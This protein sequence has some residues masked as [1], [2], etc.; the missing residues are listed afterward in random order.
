M[1]VLKIIMPIVV[2]AAIILAAIVFVIKRMLLGDTK[3]AVA[4]LS[5]VE[6]DVRKR[7]E[8]IRREIEEHEKEFAKRKAEAEADMQKRSEDAMKEIAHNREQVLESAKKESDRI[9][10][11]AAKSEERLRAQIALEMEEKAVGYSVQILQLVFSEKVT[12]EMDRL[13]IGELLDALEQVDSSSITVDAGL[14][15]FVTSHPMDAAQKAR[16]EQMLKDKFGVTV[17]VEEKI[18]KELLAGMIIKLGSLEIDASLL[19]RCQEAAAEVKK[20]AGR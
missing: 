14:A 6:I 1:D 15:E 9:L 18:R 11:N 4:R 7:E 3:R 13:F 20:S 8:N 17:K 10:E 5:Q 2:T 12:A 16:L 19:N